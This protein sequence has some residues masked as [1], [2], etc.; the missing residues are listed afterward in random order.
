MKKILLIILVITYNSINAQVSNDTIQKNLLF[1]FEQ[2]KHLQKEMKNIKLSLIQY[3]QVRTTGIFI[4]GIGMGICILGAINNP[5]TPLSKILPIYPGGLL[6][7]IGCGTMIYSNTY[8]NKAG[9]GVS[10]D[11]MKLFYI[12]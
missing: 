4:T 6:T 10:Y 9:L 5:K 8:I 2:N 11:G 1:L 7:L 3:H 12:F